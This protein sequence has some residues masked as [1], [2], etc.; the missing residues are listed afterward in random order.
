MTYF[1]AK[2]GGAACVIAGVIIPGV[3]VT[4]ASLTTGERIHVK[5]L[6]P[7]W[8]SRKV[9]VLSRNAAN[10]ISITRTIWA[11]TGDEDPAPKLK[12]AGFTIE[13]LRG[14]DFSATDLNGL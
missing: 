11:A 9:F 10:V 3:Q 8:K 6:R 7:L 13:K 2:H 12:A 5:L 4:L 1:G 14:A